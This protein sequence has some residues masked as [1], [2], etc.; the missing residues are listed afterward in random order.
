MVGTRPRYYQDT[1]EDALL[2][3][4]PLLGSAQ[5]VALANT[6][7]ENFV[8]RTGGTWCDGH[9]LKDFQAL[10]PFAPPLDPVETTK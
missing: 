2:L 6:T 5:Q 10:T 4:T 8:Q 7:L 3:T 9:S 1:Q